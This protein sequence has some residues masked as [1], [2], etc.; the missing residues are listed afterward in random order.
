VC[1]CH[2]NSADPVGPRLRLLGIYT[3]IVSTKSLRGK[4]VSHHDG[5]RSERSTMGGTSV[6][7]SGVSVRLATSQARDAIMF[8]R[9]AGFDFRKT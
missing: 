9:D 4:Y 7:N 6:Y 2:N 1:R 5:A 8:H 3:A